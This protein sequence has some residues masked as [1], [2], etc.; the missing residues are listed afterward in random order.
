MDAREIA[1]LVDGTIVGD[2]TASISDGAGIKEAD[3]GHITFLAN[4]KYTPLFE[5][6]KASIVLVPEDFFRRSDKTLILTKDPS[7]SFSRV[8]EALHPELQIHPQGVHANA[9]VH[10]SAVV[11]DNVA[12]G[13]CAVIEA[14]AAIGNNT[15]IYAGAYIGHNTR[16]G[17]NVLIYP[18]VT[19]REW[20]EIGDRVIIHSGTVIGA[21]GFGFVTENGQHKKI[22]QLGSVLI[23]DDVEIGSNVSIDRARFDKTI[24]RKGAMIDNLVQIAHNVIIGEN[25]IVVS[26]VGISGSTELGKNVVLAGKVGVV[27]HIKIADNV[28]VGAKGGVRKDITEPGQYWGVPVKPI[29]QDMKEKAALQKLPDALKKIRRLEKEINELKKGLVKDD[30]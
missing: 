6:T 7:Y 16:I 19:I 24:I 10:E 3:S 13:A 23:E 25:S 17:K 14:N 21:D 20:C 27:G 8:M 15:I 12:I 5:S 29:R 9:V 26:Q 22:P 2:E 18:N 30:T 4:T 28:V 1:R 11:G